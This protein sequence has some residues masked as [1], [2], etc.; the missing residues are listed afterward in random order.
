MD[1]LKREKRSLEQEVQV[2]VSKDRNEMTRKASLARLEQLNSSS[3][4]QHT[5]RENEALKNEVKILLQKL[6]ALNQLFESFVRTGQRPQL[7]EAAGQESDKRSRLLEEKCQLLEEELKRK[8]NE[9]AEII[10]LIWKHQSGD[11][12]NEVFA[13]IT[14]SK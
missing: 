5:R 11:L 14:D 4:A 2:L 6:E 13:L 10:N 1:N 3:L 9:T 7:P 8:K 12:M